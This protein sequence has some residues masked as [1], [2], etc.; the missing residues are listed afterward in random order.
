MRLSVG[1]S[2]YM[3]LFLVATAM[4][5]L[6]FAAENDEGTSVAAAPNSG[7]VT[8]AEEM[9][10]LKRM[11]M[12]QQR[13]IEDLRRELRAQKPATPEAGEPASNAAVGGVLTGQRSI[14]EMASTTAMVPPNPLTISGVSTS[15]TPES[16][17][18]TWTTNEPSTSRLDWG[19][20]PGALTRNAAD[21]NLVTMHSLTMT[22]LAP[23]TTYYVEITSANAAGE[24]VRQKLGES[25]KAAAPTVAASTCPPLCAPVK[26]DQIE[27][28][29]Q[30][31]LGN[32]YITPVGFMDMTAAFRDIDAGSNIGTNFGS[33]PYRTAASPQGNL[34]E[35]RLSPQNSRIGMRFD[36]IFKGTKVLG[37][38]ESDFLGFAPTNVEVNTNSY[39]LRLRLFFVDLKKGPVEFLAGQSWSLMTPGRKG[40][41]PLPGDLFYS[42][43]TDVNYVTGIP[44][45]RTPQFRLVFHP[46]NTWHFAFSAENPEQYIGGSGGGGVT[47][48]PTNLA[49][50]YASQLN[51][52]TTTQ[53]VPN[54]FPDFI[55]KMA[56]DTSAIHFEVG[57][58]LSTF[59][60]YNPTSLTMFTK[61]GGGVQAN[62]NVAVTKNFRLIVNTFWS[63]GDGRYLFG[64][65]PNLAIRT[66]GSIGLIKAA[67]TTD[68]FEFT[69]KNTLIYAYYGGSYA[70]QYA[71]VDSNNKFVGYGYPG[72]ANSQ[73]RSV[74][75]LTGGF[76][77][78]L[79]KNPA[80]GAVNFM[81][82]YAYF[83]RNP[84]FV[85]G[86]APKDTH[87]NEVF[88]NVRYTLPGSAPNLK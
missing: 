64:F 80:Y 45:G 55:A 81:A 47:V 5:T 24:T 71:V 34:S 63:D 11:L 72:S 21:P 7:A 4:S 87:M 68:G 50:A 38:W 26:S 46:S 58:V 59:K 25:A 84:W 53:S 51:N 15:A 39:S 82:Q 37:Y 74:Q 40:I 86:G 60:V 20:A 88:L 29:L 12:E 65:S 14:G 2:R 42:Q 3:S 76:N 85:A 27:W 56:V 35:V 22:G 77:Q 61:V 1:W 75:E 10:E 30:L 83:T 62:A 36:S 52:G 41:S 32:S 44:W 31:R 16:V 70:G 57:G 49:S 78:T 8:S 6:T 13:Q 73:N 18:V 48:L 23:G 9:M 69:H 17:T 19:T 54:Y 66:D 28:P 79:W 43:A 67:G 33:F